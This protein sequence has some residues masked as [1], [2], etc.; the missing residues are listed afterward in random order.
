VIYLLDGPACNAPELICNAGTPFSQVAAYFSAGQTVI[1]VVDGLNVDSVGDLVV[2]V[3]QVM[4][5]AET[6]LCTNVHDD[7]QDGYANCVD[8]DCY[9]D[10]SCPFDVCP[11]PHLGS[12]LGAPVINGD[13]TTAKNDTK[14]SCGGG[15]AP[16]LA[17]TWKAP[18]AAV[19]KIDTSG[20][21]FD[22]VLYARRGCTGAEVACNDTYGLNGDKIMVTLQKSEEIVIFV[23]GYSTSSAGAFKLNIA[24]DHVT[25]EAGLCEDGVDNDI[26]GKKDCADAD[27]AM[28]PACPEACIFA[29]LG[30]ALGQKVAQGTT[31]SGLSVL[32]GPCGGGTAKEMAYRWK[33]PIDGIYAFDTAGSSFDTV[34]YLLDGNCAGQ[35][36]RCDDDEGSTL[37]S[38]VLHE[39]TKNQTVVI[40]VDGKGTAAGNFILNINIAPVPAETGLCY[41]GIDNDADTLVDCFD[42][43]CQTDPVCLTPCADIDLGAAMGA[44]V[45]SGTTVGAGDELTGACGGSGATDL[46]YAWIAPAAGSYQFDTLGSGFDTVL[47]LKSE[48]CTRELRCEDN[49][50]F[51]MQSKLTQ[52][53]QKGQRV[54][55]VVDGYSTPNAGDFVLNIKSL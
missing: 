40:V 35:A 51:V 44:P 8:A 13:T 48:S 39:M 3:R 43:D 9:I 21:V 30:K 18:T 24:L 11:A 41:E 32:G 38:S 55:I 27:C 20:S 53:L 33:A 10:P 6:G 54:V 12:V 52:T 37:Q 34:L 29:D 28:A 1:V 5:T 2:N 4:L 7:D 31:A 45:V 23:D 49:S 14:G 25:S 17:F 42:D 47:Y 26:D 19:Y 16:E 15:S 36:L 50:G 46:A 22:G